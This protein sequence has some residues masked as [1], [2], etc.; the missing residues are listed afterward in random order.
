M[1]A[2]SDIITVIIWGLVISDKNQ[3]HILKYT[4]YS[5]NPFNLTVYK[6]S[7]YMLKNPCNCYSVVRKHRRMYKYI[8][9]KGCEA[10]TILKKEFVLAFIPVRTLRTKQ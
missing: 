5:L 9:L 4:T 10:R 2:A 6:T 8:N 3:C 1:T 7:H